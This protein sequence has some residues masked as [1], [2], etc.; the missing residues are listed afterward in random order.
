MAR[1]VHTS[2]PD[3]QGRVTHHL[4]EP[5]GQPQAGEWIILTL[6]ADV[7]LVALGD[8]TTKT[9]EHRIL[10]HGQDRLQDVDQ[11]AKVTHADGTLIHDP[12]APADDDE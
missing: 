12:S 9:H 8:G 11:R 5:I 4:S 7:A 6:P 10:M 3:H 1:V 2:A